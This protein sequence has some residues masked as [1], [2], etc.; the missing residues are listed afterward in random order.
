[1]GKFGVDFRHYRHL[2]DRFANEGG[3]LGCTGLKTLRQFLPEDQRHLF[4]P[5]WRYHDNLFAWYAPV[6]GTPGRSYELVLF[7]TGR[8]ADELSMEEYALLSGAL[9]AE[10][11]YEYI[12]NY[13]RRMFSS[14]SAVFWMFNDSWPATHGWTT[15]DYYL[16][17]KLCYYPVRRAFEPVSVFIAEEDGQL[18]VY[19]VNETDQPVSAKLLWGGF[20]LSG[21]RWQPCEIE[22]ELKPNSS[23]RLASLEIGEA[24]PDKASGGFAAELVLEDGTI[25]RDR[26]FFETFADLQLRQPDIKVEVRDGRACFLSDCYAWAVC[27]DVEGE[28]DLADNCFDLLPCVPYSIAWECNEQPKVVWCGSAALADGS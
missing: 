3:V 11:L 23:V 5:S 18:A 19:G 17:K 21:S 25:R 22:I 4:S 26:F 7:W 24:V 1:L 2:I 20:V 10:G 15:Q 6:A 16:R 14:A 12:R 13:H 28:A 8:P 27:L 9:Q